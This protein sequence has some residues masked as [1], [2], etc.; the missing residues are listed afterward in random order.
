MV[1]QE[2]VVYLIHRCGGPP[3]SPAVR[4]FHQNLRFWFPFPKGK[5]RRGCRRPKASLKEGGGN[6]VGVDGGSPFPMCGEAAHHLR[7]AQHRWPPR[8]HIIAALPHIVCPAQA[9]SSHSHAPRRSRGACCFFHPAPKVGA[10]G[11]KSTIPAGIGN[12]GC[13]VAVNRIWAPPTAPCLPLG[14]GGP[15]QRWMRYKT[16]PCG[17][18]QSTAAN[19][20]LP[21]PWGRG[22]AAA[23]DEVQNHPPRHQPIDRRQPPPQF[24]Q[25]RIPISNPPHNLQKI[26][27]FI[28]RSLNINKKIGVKFQKALDKSFEK[29][30]SIVIG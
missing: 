28:F 26:N 10:E 24:P 9:T 30:Y 2:V 19:L 15:P 25:F 17:I 22:T 1:P 16:I 27:L 11:E 18:N 29:W 14:E 12:R 21:S 5:A 3:L 20:S 6:A 4:P 13:R 7:E 8:G 23:V